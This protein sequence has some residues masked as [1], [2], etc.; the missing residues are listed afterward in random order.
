MYGAEADLA[1][2]SAYLNGCCDGGVDP[3][4]VRLEALCF[5]RSVCSLLPSDTLCS[6]ILST[7]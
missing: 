5:G 1:G 2:V 3:H 7:C 6:I 4:A